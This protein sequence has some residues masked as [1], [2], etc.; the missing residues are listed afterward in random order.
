MRLQQQVLAVGLP[1]AIAAGALL[2]SFSRS[3]TE[4]IMIGE[5]AQRVLPQALDAAARLSAAASSGRE[6]QLLPRVQAI[7]GFTGAAYAAVVSPDGRVLAHTNVLEQ[8]RRRVDPASRRALD[9]SAPLVEEIFEAGGR[10][11]LLGLPIWR[12]EEEFLLSAKDRTRAGTLLLSLPLDVTL[13]SARRVG[14]QVVGLVL[15]FCAAA[16]AVTLG[17]LRMILRRL[18]AVADATVKVAAGDYG[19]SVP[20]GSSDELGDLAGAFNRMSAALSRTVVSRNR[21]EETLSVARA[22]LEASADGILVVAADMRIVTFNRRFVEMWGLREEDVADRDNRR[23]V[24]LVTP[25]VS[26]PEGFLKRSTHDYDDFEVGEQRD[27]VRLKDGRVFERISRP[28]RLEKTAVGRTLTFRDLTPFMEAERMKGQFM[29]NVSHELRTPLNAVVGAAGLLRGTRLDDDQRESVET[30]SRAA[31]SLLDLIDDVLD[32][33]KIEADRMTMERVVL[34]PA[35]VLSDAAALVAPGAAEKGLRLTVDAGEASALRA[36]GDP[37]RL[38]QVLLNMLSNAVKFTESGEI[39][40]ALRVRELG[41]PFVELE[42]SVR[43]TGIGITREQGARLF[44]PFAQADGSTTRRYGGTGL[45]LAISKSLAALM[46]GEFGYESVP[47]RGSRFWLKVPLERAEAAAGHG[48]DGALPPPPPPS[49]PRDHLRVLIVEDN[50][51]NRRLLVRQLARLGCS[52]EAAANG[53]EALEALNSG[54]YGL[55]FMDCQMPG[56]DG[57]EAAAEVRRR[58][59]GRRRVP[60]VAF[61][62]NATDADRRRCLEAGMDDFIGKPATLEAL[63]AAIERWDLPVDERVLGNFVE[64]AGAGGDARGLFEDFSTDAAANLAAARAAA[65][66]GDPA[67]AARA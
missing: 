66:R 42:F 1:A 63:S 3:A 26:D 4:S 17:L 39:A 37:G 49:R 40:A 38:R 64:L 62:A 45:G 28:Y 33:S 53:A 46:G 8:G 9:S 11:L 14:R 24:L 10:R 54:E 18:R 65:G 2:A 6:A 22:T 51:I 41:E 52:S 5:A 36:Y 27:V 20:A 44:E 25:Q 57:L 15:V 35:D 30:L 59:A 34:R 7:Q 47:E 16:L 19:A 60:I 56:M 48:G 61:T 29:A 23:L 13:E 55:V 12:P 67:S 32:F 58:E 50:A 31:Q 21:L 43:D